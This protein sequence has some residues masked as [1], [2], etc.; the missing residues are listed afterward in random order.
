MRLARVIT[1]VLAGCYY[2]DSMSEQNS[3]S[4]SCSA[5]TLP[6]DWHARAGAYAPIHI[7]CMIVC[8]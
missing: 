1:V 5:T 3:K 6:S 2:F 7:I 8:K 4:Q